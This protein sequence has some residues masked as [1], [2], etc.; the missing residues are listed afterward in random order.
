M[1]V[2]RLG[3][4]RNVQKHARHGVGALPPADPHGMLSLGVALVRLRECFVVGPEMAL[5]VNVSNE[6]IFLQA[7]L[8][9]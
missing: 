3:S 7:A 2:N 9:A 5:D 1:V 4:G 8:A 6:T